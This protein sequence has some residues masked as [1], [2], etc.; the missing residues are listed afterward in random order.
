MAKGNMLLG[1]SRGK[2]GSLVFSRTNGQ[3]VVRARAE[4]V[5]NPQTEKQT[6][7]RIILQTISQAYSNAAAIVDH[8]FEGVA[9]GQKSMSYFMQINMDAL[10]QRVAN[11]ISSG[12]QMYEIQSF[13]PL[14][15]SI[16]ATNAYIVSKGKLPKVAVI[17]AAD[18]GKAAVAVPENT[19]QSIIERYGLQR[20]DQLTFVAIVADDID[21]ASF[22]F[23]RVILSPV[24]ENGDEL[25]LDTPFIEN[26]A[27]NAA[28]PRNEGFFS[29]IAFANAAVTFGFG[30]TYL[31][32]AGVIVSRQGSDG[33]WQ[34]STCQLFMNETS[35]AGYDLQQCL[36]LAKSSGI[37][38]LNERY[39]NNAGNGRLAVAGVAPSTT[40]VIRVSYNSSTGSVTGSTQSGVQLEN[41][42]LTCPIGDTVTLTATTELPGVTTKW[43]VNGE[44]KH[45]G[46]TYT[47]Q[48]D[49]SVTINVTWE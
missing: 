44:V 8:S 32:G 34:R 36:D 26:G 48:A 1:M 20:G 46:D 9:P 3:Q 11:A 38:T 40:A 49:A 33:S 37:D 41:N 35:N 22:Q 42:T 6:I 28:N 30:K 10:R 45:S 18:D 47:F 19:Y 14:K 2:V 25:P 4:Q 5:K 43:S 27:I 23:A 7:Q 31:M 15:S 29:S 21:D 16:F 39:L 24:D 17:D 12:T 13:S